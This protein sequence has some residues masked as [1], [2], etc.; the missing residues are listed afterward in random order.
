MYTQIFEKKK[1][2]DRVVHAAS[3]RN[4]ET[5]DTQADSMCVGHEGVPSVRNSRDDD[6]SIDSD[7]ITHA[8]TKK[9]Y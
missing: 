1:A 9:M 3:V 8:A 4:L 7:E 6:E 5:R 2:S